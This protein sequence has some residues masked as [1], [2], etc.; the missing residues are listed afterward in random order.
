[1]KINLHSLELGENG[2]DVVFQDLATLSEEVSIKLNLIEKEIIREY[3]NKQEDS[4]G[5]EK[6]GNEIRYNDVLK[7][8][9]NTSFEDSVIVKLT[10]NRRSFVKIFIDSLN[11]FHPK[12]IYFFIL[13]NDFGINSKLV[14]PSFLRINEA[15]EE[16]NKIFSFFEPNF[17]LDRIKF[18]EM[19][20]F[21]NYRIELIEE[22]RGYSK[23]HLNK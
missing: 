19:K 4:I 22:G 16:L 11:D 13:E 12:N 7:K 21:D 10:E 20:G 5:I 17:G 14:D 1:M 18:I 6:L 3:L 2:V 8:T 9:F 15:K 23:I